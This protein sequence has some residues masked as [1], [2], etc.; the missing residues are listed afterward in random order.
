MPNSRQHHYRL[1]LDDALDA[2][3]RALRYG[4]RPG[5]INRCLIE[6]AIV[7]PYSGYYRAIRF[8]AAALVESMA[9]N[10][11]FVDGNKRTTLILLNLLLER[12]GYRLTPSEGGGSIQ[13]EVEDVILDV[14][15]KQ[16][17]FDDLAEWFRKRITRA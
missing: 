9:G 10:H 14:V 16:L 6:S 2:H 7:R 4:G 17:S 11:G 12:S 3:E 13:K 8:K 5:V 15:G 1:T